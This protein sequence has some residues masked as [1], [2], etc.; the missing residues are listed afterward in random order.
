MVGLV[1]MGVTVFEGFILASEGGGPRT[2]TE[3]ERIGR[4]ESGGARTNT[5]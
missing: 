1:G 4:G 3:K 2:N 5:E